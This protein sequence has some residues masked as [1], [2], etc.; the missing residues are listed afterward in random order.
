MGSTC[1][2]QEIAKFEFR[3]A[4]GCVWLIVKQV[5]ACRQLAELREQ[6]V[7]G[8]VQLDNMRLGQHQRLHPGPTQLLLLPKVADEKAERLRDE[9]L[10]VVCSSDRRLRSVFRFSTRAAGRAAP[11]QWRGIGRAR[12]RLSQSSEG[13]VHQCFNEIFLAVPSQVDLERKQL[14]EISVHLLPLR[15]RLLAVT[16][17]DAALHQLHVAAAL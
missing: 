4:R 13:K 17:L 7:E 15:D 12:V 3:W 2:D 14:E 5:P 9:V 11:T 8:G 10:V 16:F 6:V 1:V